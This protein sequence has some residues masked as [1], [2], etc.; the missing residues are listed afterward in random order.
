MMGRL[1]HTVEEVTARIAARS[2]DLRAAYVARTDKARRDGK[3]RARLSCGNLAHSFAAAPLG[4]R[5]ALR[6]ADAA[7]YRSKREGRDR[8]IVAD[9]P[10][11]AETQLNTVKIEKP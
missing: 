11:A 5:L 1:H 10:P 6:S 3:G 7:L 4:D 8:V 2:R 9:I